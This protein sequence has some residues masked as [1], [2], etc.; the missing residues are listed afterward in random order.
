LAEIRDAS[1]LKGTL[2]YFVAFEN[3]A[4]TEREGV[5]RITARAVIG[6]PHFKDG[7]VGDWVRVTAKELPRI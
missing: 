3:P 6:G 5:A 2:K 7:K 4:Q 1:D